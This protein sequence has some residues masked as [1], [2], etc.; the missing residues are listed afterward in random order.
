MSG[1]EDFAGWGADSIVWTRD[2]L[3]AAARLERLA[4][5]SFCDRDHPSGCRSVSLA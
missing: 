5:Y 3:E 2:T 1:F 4:F